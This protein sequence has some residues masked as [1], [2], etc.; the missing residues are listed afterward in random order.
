MRPKP[1]ISVPV[2]VSGILHGVATPRNSY[3]NLTGRRWG[4]AIAVVVVLVV[5]VL[6][7]VSVVAM[8]GCSE[9][10]LG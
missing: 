8:P 5:V 3:R 9:G 10:F 2:A 7:V 4:S 1:A 6:V